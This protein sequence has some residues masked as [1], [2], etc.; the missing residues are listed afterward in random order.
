MYQQS[1]SLSSAVEGA[2]PVMAMATSIRRGE[3]NALQMPAVCGAALHCAN[4]SVTDTAAMSSLSSSFSPLPV[5]PGA[6]K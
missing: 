3:P 5:V 2:R 6:G 4:Q 1:S